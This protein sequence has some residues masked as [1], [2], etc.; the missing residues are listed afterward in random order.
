MIYVL[1][2]TI[3][4]L[5]MN[6]LSID[7]IINPEQDSELTI[8]KILGILKGHL[9]DIRKYKIYP[10]LSELVGMAVRLE[11]LKKTI[12]KTVSSDND[13]FILDED[14]TTIGEQ[15]PDKDYSEDAGDPTDFINWVISQINPILDEGIA[16]YDFADQNMELKLINGNPLFKEEGYL[17]IPDNNTAVYNIYRFNCL[18]LK[19]EKH[20][21]R[22]IKTEFIQSVPRID[23]NEDKIQ[24][25]ILL[26]YIANITLPVYLSETELDFPYEENVYQVARKQL[27]NTLS[28]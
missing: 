26:E 9:A 6:S 10:A 22:A 24:H 7:R 18:L 15:Q 25:R 3:L 14:I 27:L 20:T 11:N 21:E 8:Y 1:F 17:I 2:D 28:S 12:T 5:I 13:L 19:N 16:I 23:I 4:G